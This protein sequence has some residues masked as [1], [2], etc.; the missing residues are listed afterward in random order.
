MYATSCGSRLVQREDEKP[1]AI[2]KRLAVFEA[3]TLP[4]LEFFKKE[5]N[6]VAVDGEGSIEEVY[7]E[8]KREIVK[9]R[10]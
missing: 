10:E 6:L 7:E 8:I 3:Q 1:A 5:G 9:R 2:R 4:V